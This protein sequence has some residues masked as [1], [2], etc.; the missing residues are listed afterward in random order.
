MSSDDRKER[1]SRL[2]AERVRRRKMGLF[3][4]AHSF[5]RDFDM[6]VAV[7]LHKGGQYYPLPCLYDLAL[8]FG[9]KPLLVLRH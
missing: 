4:K 2:S 3:K 6:E 9:L 5:T 1:T 7:I 8:N